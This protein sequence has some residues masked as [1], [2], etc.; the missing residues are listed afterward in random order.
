MG[1]AGAGL[2]VPAINLPPRASLTASA[3]LEFFD[4]TPQFDP[5]TQS[6]SVYRGCRSNLR[7]VAAHFSGIDHT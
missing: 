4:T 2:G 1:V 3:V 7:W 5:I 6:S